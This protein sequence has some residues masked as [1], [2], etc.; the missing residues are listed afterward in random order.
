MLFRG[1]L[2]DAGA[3]VPDEAS[4]LHRVSAAATCALAA[5]VSAPGGLQAIVPD[6]RRAPDAELAL[7]GAGGSRGSRG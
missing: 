1:V 4:S 3:E 2:E 5:R 6:Y 7:Q